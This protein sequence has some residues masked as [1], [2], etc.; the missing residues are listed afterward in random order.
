M[1]V[2]SEHVYHYGFIEQT[3]HIKCYFYKLAD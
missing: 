2:N 1:L 3:R